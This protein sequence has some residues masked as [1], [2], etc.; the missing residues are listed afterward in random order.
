[1]IFRRQAP[2]RSQVRRLR[3]SVGHEALALQGTWNDSRRIS[4][5]RSRTFP[6]F[7]M[8]GIVEQRV[9]RFPLHD[10]ISR[11]NDWYKQSI[12]QVISAEG[13]KP[14]VQVDYKGEAKSFTPEEI[15]SMILIK[16]K[17]N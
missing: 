3:R 14:K 7:T 15:S 10:R 13:G 16:L 2:H 4:F 6:L 17:V 8:T 5:D 12:L 1:M 11:M 9:K